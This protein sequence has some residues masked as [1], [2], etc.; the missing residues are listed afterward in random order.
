MLERQLDLTYK[1]LWRTSAAVLGLA[2][3]SFGW[4]WL[5]KLVRAFGG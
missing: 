1:I 5:S 3:A 2:G 4:D